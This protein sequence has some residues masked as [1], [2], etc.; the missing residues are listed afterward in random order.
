VAW[1]LGEPDQSGTQELTFPEKVIPAR[2]KT[3]AEPTRRIDFKR[4][5]F[6]AAIRHDIDQPRR[7]VRQIAA[8]SGFKVC[9]GSPAGALGIAQI[10]PNTADSWQVDP[11][12]PVASLDAAAKQMNRYEEQL[13]SYELALAA[14]NAGPGAVARYGGI[15]PYKE[16]QNYIKKIMSDGY[17]WGLQNAVLELPDG[18]TPTFEKRL[19]ALIQ[20]VKRHGGN[21][22]VVSG[23]RSYQEQKMLWEE[24]KV[25]HGGWRNAR[26]WVAP[27]G[28]SSHGRGTAA[29]LS[30]ELDLAH[31][32]AAKHGLRFG[33]S[34]EPWHVSISGH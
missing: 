26:K 32:L 28:C 22:T 7:F 20:D 9:V 8:E 3:P 11:L 4:L 13:G 14:Y 34:N 17:I 30:G 31:K 10:M 27:A 12:D 21:V 1:A 15:P 19:N 29:D 6:E 5:A 23:F 2:A 33:I 25:K 18:Y 16:T 24:A